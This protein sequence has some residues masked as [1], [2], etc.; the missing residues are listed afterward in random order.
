MS[1][2][3]CR[4]DKIIACTVVDEIS[5]LGTPIFDFYHVNIKHPKKRQV[6]SANFN[7][8]SF[9]KSSGK[10]DTCRKEKTDYLEC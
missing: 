5:K 2:I 1:S 8:G 7:T 3:K 4:E 10:N 6:F 9:L